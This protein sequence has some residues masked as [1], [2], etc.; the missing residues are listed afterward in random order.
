MGNDLDI[1]PG[2]VADLASLGK[3]ASRPPPRQTLT[4]FGLPS[5]IT[6]CERQH[7]NHIVPSQ[8]RSALPVADRSDISTKITLQHHGYV[9]VRA[10]MFSNMERGIIQ[11][12]GKPAQVLRTAWSRTGNRNDIHHFIKLGFDESR[13]GKGRKVL[14]ALFGFSRE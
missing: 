1:I 4:T 2:N 13:E 3:A 6:R 12:R 9:T 14:N 8:Q 11:G 7:H 5:G 10:T